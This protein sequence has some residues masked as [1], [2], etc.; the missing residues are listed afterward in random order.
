MNKKTIDTSSLLEGCALNKRSKE[1]I[2]PIFCP[3][4]NQTYNYHHHRH[5][6]L[7][8]YQKYCW[9]MLLAFSINFVGFVWWWW[10]L[11]SLPVQSLCVYVKEKAAQKRENCIQ[12]RH[13]LGP[14]CG[15][16]QHSNFQTHL[17]I[18]QSFFRSS[19]FIMI[20]ILA[21]SMYNRIHAMLFI[22]IPQE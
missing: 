14:F 18:H 11:S 13:C 5:L 22:T 19:L 15:S 4:P 21:P 16:E 7:R 9:C 10:V 17:S 6:C 3:F 20:V 12:D 2:F 8:R 1:G